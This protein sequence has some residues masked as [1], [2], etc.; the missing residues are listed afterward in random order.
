MTKQPSYRFTD[1]DELW[2]E[3]KLSDGISKIG[4][5]IHGTPVYSEDGDY[6]FING[7]NLIDGK[8]F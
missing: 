4:D 1:Y 2:E 3:K 5:G 6:Y 8:I 7:N